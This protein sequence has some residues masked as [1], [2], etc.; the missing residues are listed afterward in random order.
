MSI[1]YL[2][3]LE[4][5]GQ[6]MNV[7]RLFVF[8]RWL[9]QPSPVG[10][11][12]QL[13]LWVIDFIFKPYLF[14]SKKENKTKPFYICI[15]LVSDNMVHFP[16]HLPHFIF[17]ILNSSQYVLL[18]IFLIRISILEKKNHEASGFS[19]LQSLIYKQMD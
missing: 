17:P 3:E 18:N 9:R 13:L 16:P 7:L 14:E 4:L 1:G 11:C 15:D 8:S 10:Q 5:L 19:R 12:P 6:L 2:P